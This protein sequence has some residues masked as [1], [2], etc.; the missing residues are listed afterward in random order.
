MNWL[1]LA[2]ALVGI[3]WG[4]QVAFKPEGVARAWGLSGLASSSAA[5]LI[6][7]VLGIWMV[8]LGVFIAFQAINVD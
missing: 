4:A 2:V 5:M 6:A 3:W 7:R 8:L 1:G